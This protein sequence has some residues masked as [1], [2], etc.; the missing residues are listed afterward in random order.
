M[1]ILKLAFIDLGRASIDLEDYWSD[2]ELIINRFLNIQILLRL[3]YQ[4]IIEESL[5]LVAMK[6]EYMT[7][8]LQGVGNPKN[9]ES[10]L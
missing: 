3:T 8:D 5:N 10:Q 6:Q 2:S 1:W 9:Q 4:I 7:E